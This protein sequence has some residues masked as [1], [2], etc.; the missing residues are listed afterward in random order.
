VQKVV[1]KGCCAEN[2]QGKSNPIETLGEVVA[3]STCCNSFA[4]ALEGQDQS[5]TAF[6]SRVV[7]G[8]DDFARTKSGSSVVALMHV[9][10]AHAAGCC[11]SPSSESSFIGFD[12]ETESSVEFVRYLPTDVEASKRIHDEDTFIAVNQLGAHQQN[13][14]E[15]ICCNAVDQTQDDV[16]S[17]AGNSESDNDAE[18]NCCNESEVEPT[19]S[20]SVNM[21]VGHDSKN[22]ATA[23][24]QFSSSNTKKGA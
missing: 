20:R 3:S 6:S 12:F 9:S 11:G 7:A 19:T 13:V 10:G 23:V 21:F 4:F 8:G 15:N 1:D 24:F 14:T 22:T 5:N 16:L 18:F 17:F 2:A